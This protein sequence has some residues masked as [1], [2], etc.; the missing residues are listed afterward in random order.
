MGVK[1]LI[2][3]A[4]DFGRSGGANRGIIKAHAEGIVTS[5][6]LSVQGAAAAE[7]VALAAENPKLGVG[8]CF[9][10]TGGHPLLP[11]AEIPSLVDASGR[12]PAG[13]EALAPARLDDV[14]AEA[15]TQ[16]RRFRELMTARPTHLDTYLGV[17][18]V[19]VVLEAVLS[20]SWETGLPVRSLSPEMRERLRYERIPTPDHF[21]SD[22]S[23][24]GVSL[25]KLAHSLAEIGSGT[26]ELLCRPAE[27]EDGLPPGDSESRQKELEIL[28]H[29][30][31][32]QA[33][34]AAGI[35]LVSYAPESA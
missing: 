31:A 13:A 34:R 27:A 29:A 14:L 5:T 12:L 19:P 10:F 23:G 28:T 30:E 16:L 11:P 7:A 26:S 24:P 2:V 22:F 9:V 3:N 8:L 21:V 6:T 25:E 17:H 35:Q 20:L 1:R 4:E 32:R 15:R 18:A 33:V